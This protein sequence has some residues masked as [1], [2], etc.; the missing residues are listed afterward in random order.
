MFSKSAHLYDAIYR[1]FHDFEA[2]FARLHQLIAVAKQSTGNA[3]LDVASGTGPHLAYW[4]RQYSVEG[5][6]LDPAMLAVARERAPD[7]PLH[8]ADMAT[9]DLGKRFDV[10][11]C[12]GSALPSVRTVERLD[13]TISTFA[14]H[15]QPGGVALV[16]PFFPP[17]S[18]DVG[19]VSALFVDEPARKIARM[20]VAE[21][22]GDL[23]VLN[24]H[25]LVATTAGVE[26]FTERHELGLFR[27]DD[28]LRA[29][30]TAGLT[31][32][33]D[34]EGISGRGL[35]VGSRPTADERGT[36]PSPQPH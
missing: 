34:E 19:R 8:Q 32:S 35:Y 3:L 9:F 31:V 1:S 13:A 18:W 20:N 15:L 5:L 29:F 27:H 12:L 30:A 14:R 4:A 24:F 2:E 25:Y 33:Y 10:I 36:D 22:E 26:H 23:A 28:Y 11:A 21:R 7:I 6:D 16:E 17:E